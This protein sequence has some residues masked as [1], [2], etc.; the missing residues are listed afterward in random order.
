MR[1]A[2]VILVC[3]AACK[4]MPW[5]QRGQYTRPGPTE[6]ELYWEQG[7]PVDT[8]DGFR[9]YAT[10]QVAEPIPAL[11]GPCG[12]PASAHVLTVEMA[13]TLPGIETVHVST[14]GAVIVSNGQVVAATAPP[15]CTQLPSAI[16]A[17]HAGFLWKS[18]SLPDNPHQL[19][20]VDRVG[21]QTR[22]RLLHH[23][24]TGTLTETFSFVIADDAT[25]DVAR[26][27]RIGNEGQEIYTD[28]PHGVFHWDPDQNRY[29]RGPKMSRSRREAF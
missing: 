3:L 16:V 18:G 22:Q 11:A 24:P 9:S 15:D 28:E 8:L 10:G 27:M 20:V 29:V 25:P 14:H 5:N 26:R 23:G 17:V 1:I 2:S 7:A 13:H 19:V 4:S 21:A 12:M 6:N